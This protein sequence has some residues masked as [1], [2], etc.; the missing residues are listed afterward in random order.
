MRH[1]FLEL[2][3]KK[4]LFSK[5]EISKTLIELKLVAKSYDGLLVSQVNTQYILKYCIGDV[6][7]KN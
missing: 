7:H 3:P 5:N 4:F 6:S 2:E 1:R